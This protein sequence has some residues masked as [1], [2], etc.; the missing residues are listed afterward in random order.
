VPGGAG[1]AAESG[2][3]GGFGGGAVGAPQS[4]HCAACSSSCGAP[5]TSQRLPE[6]RIA[7]RV[8]QMVRLLLSAAL[9]GACSACGAG[10]VTFPGPPEL[11]LG[12]GFADFVP[13]ADGDAVPIIHGLQGG[14]HIWGSLRAR[15]LDPTALRLRFTVTL[16]GASSFEALREDTVDLDGTTDG[17]TPG[18]HLGSAVIFKDVRR[19]EGQPCDWTLDVTDREGRTAA[20]AC[21]GIV[22]TG[23]PSLDGGALDD[24]AAG[25]GGAAVDGGAADG[26]ATG[27]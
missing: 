19:V 14:Y 15:Y 24:G 18:T 21:H 6:K 1:G 2:R 8:Y 22:P 27:G 16:A 4:K 5:H 3:G 25:D 12:T 13:V 9:C 26:G 10:P 7:T 17:L 20:A 11:E 23:G